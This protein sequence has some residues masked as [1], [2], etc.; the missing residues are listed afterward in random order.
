[1][2]EVLQIIKQKIDARV[3]VKLENR[4]KKVGMTVERYV[5]LFLTNG[6][7]PIR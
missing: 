1:M 6:V 2:K 4:A 3:W 7:E 5:S